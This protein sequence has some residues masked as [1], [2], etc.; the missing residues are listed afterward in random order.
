MMMT[1]DKQKFGTAPEQLIV[2]FPST[3]VSLQ[4][5]FQSDLLAVTRLSCFRHFANKTQWCQRVKRQ[6][7][8]K[9]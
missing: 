4:C 3:V 7:V 5:A 9:G 6:L 2:S 8:E 1:F